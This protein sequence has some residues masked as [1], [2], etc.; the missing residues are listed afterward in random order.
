[1]KPFFI[2]KKSE[3]EE[4]FMA[5]LDSSDKVE[6]WYKNREGE[7]KYFAIPYIE[8]GKEWA[9]YVDFIVKFKDGRIGLFDTKSG[10]TAKDAKAKAEA[11]QKYIKEQNSKGKKLIGGIIAQRRKGDETLYLNNNEPYD[12]NQNDFSKWKVLDLNEV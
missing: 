2:A 5:L 12:F 6:W 10:I 3:P 8:N 1:M 11:L 4:I 9:F 7:K